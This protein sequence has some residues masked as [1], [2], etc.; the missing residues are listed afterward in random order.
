MSD[1]SLTPRLERAVRALFG[2]SD[3]TLA[4]EMMVND[5]AAEQLAV[6]L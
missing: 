3:V 5:Y 6:V 2:P 1:V 4:T